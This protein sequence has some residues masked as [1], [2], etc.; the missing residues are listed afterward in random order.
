MGSCIA[1]G[2]RDFFEVCVFDKDKQKLG[3]NSGLQTKTSVIDLVKDSDVLILA[4]KPQDF[5]ALLN[6]I[7]PFIQDQ[8]VISIAA[9][10]TTGYIEKILSGSRVIRVM[11]NMAV[12][13]QAAETGLAGGRNAGEDDL[14]LAKELFGLLG[15]VWMVKEEMIDS[16]TAISGS[17]PAYILYDMEI[18]KIDPLKIPIERKNEYIQWLKKAALDV[19]FDPKM[20]LDLAVCT[21]ASTIQLSMQPGSSPAQLR[22]MITSAGGTTEAAIK[23]LSQNGSWSQ[24]AQA[25]RQRAKELSR[26]E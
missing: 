3:N 22:K 23:I 7:K 25:A 15:K 14:A 6:E 20:A 11:P 4:V 9:G 13:I 1:S 8:L 18:S 26:R 21:T 2:A 10:I 5:D 24:A 12:K 16:I 19:G 17:G